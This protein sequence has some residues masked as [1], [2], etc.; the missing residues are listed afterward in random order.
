MIS[1]KHSSLKTNVRK[2]IG[3]N[4]NNKIK[5][6]TKVSQRKNHNINIFKS[7]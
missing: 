4:Y 7:S 1:K 3:E 6:L 5:S 2:M